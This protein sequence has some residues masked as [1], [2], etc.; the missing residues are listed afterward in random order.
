MKYFCNKVRAKSAQKDLIKNLLYICPSQNGGLEKNNHWSDR[1]ALHS[2][3]KYFMSI[4]CGLVLLILN[5]LPRLKI[6]QFQPEPGHAALVDALQGLQNHFNEDL[7][8]VLRYQFICQAQN[9]L[10]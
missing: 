3:V 10:R 4:K 6:G 9:I 5:R 1:L 7:F 2:P 8:I